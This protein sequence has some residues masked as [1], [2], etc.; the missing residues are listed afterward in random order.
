MTTDALTHLLTNPY[1][2]TF[3]AGFLLGM[4]TQRRIVRWALGGRA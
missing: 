2:Y 3:L 4:Q 1:A